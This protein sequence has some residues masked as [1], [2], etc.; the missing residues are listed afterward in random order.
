VAT[1]VD[2]ASLTQAIVDFAHR[3]DIQAGAYTDY[4]IQ[5]AQEAIENDIPDLN[6]GNYI[7]FQENAYPPTAI[8]NGVAPVPT[9]WLGPK[10]LYVLDGSGNQF[11]LTFVS[12]AWLYDA[13]PVRQPQGLPTYI[14]RDVL[15]SGAFP[16]S[17]SSQTFTTTT[18]QTIFALTV[19]G[20]PVLIV[21]LDG[22]VLV[23][24]TDYSISGSNLVLANGA[25][26]DQTLY[27]QYAAPI[28]GG[29]PTATGTTA[30]VFGPY[31]DSA[32]TL[33]GTYYQS[34]P[35]LSESA[36]TNWMVDSAP[37][38]LHA[39]CMVECAK[40]LLDDVML[41]RW[42]PRYQQK[43]KAVVDADKAERWAASTMEVQVG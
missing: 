28:L 37:S 14:A 9:D 25:F 27:V 39:A 3:A 6:F 23:P 16:I 35:L 42:E 31:P 34:A 43:L 15:S 19:V 2:Y 24:G 10:V 8:T 4:F 29:A 33:Q 17:P 38:M 11:T 13:Y 26:L 12:V 40:F 32:Y 22:S 1:I 7:R 18:G 41:Q 21:S 30:F 36:T 20:S 5:Q